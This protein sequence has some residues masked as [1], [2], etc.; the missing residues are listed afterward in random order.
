[1]GKFNKE[2][3]E[4]YPANR[5]FDSPCGKIKGSKPTEDSP[6]TVIAPWGELRLY[7]NGAEVQKKLRNYGEE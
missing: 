1:M 6:W 4:S 2:V 5:V 7:G 3:Q